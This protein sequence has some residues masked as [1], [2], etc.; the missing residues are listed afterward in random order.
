MHIIEQKVKVKVNHSCTVQSPLYVKALLVA[1][2]N[3]YQE[4]NPT[5]NLLHIDKE[6]TIT[7][8]SH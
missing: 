4:L 7:I 2:L 6:S 5:F 3:A 8:L 1:T